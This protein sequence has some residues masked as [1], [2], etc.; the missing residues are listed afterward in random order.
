MYNDLLKNNAIHEKMAKLNSIISDSGAVIVA[1]SGGIDSSFLLWACKNIMK[2]EKLLAVTFFSAITPQKEIILAKKTADLLDVKHLIVPSHEMENEDFLKND[3]L[4]CYYCKR[5]RLRYAVEYKE[6]HV[7]K[8]IFDGTQMDDLQDYR[9]GLK[10]LKE[11]NIISP[12]VE[13]GINKADIYSLCKLNSLSFSKQKSE[14][15]LATRI[16]TGQMI[17]VNILRKIEKSEEAIR[18]LGIEFIRARYSYGEIRLEVEKVD[19]PIVLEKKNKILNA[20]EKIGFS[21][22]SLDLK[23]YKSVKRENKNG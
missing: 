21:R 11:N 15:C 8:T 1:Y 18:E 10:A 20:L 9:P 13:A 2:N 16:K 19:M 4:R 17:E 14:S 12:F 6:K 23:E 7:F 3:V 5:D 22:V